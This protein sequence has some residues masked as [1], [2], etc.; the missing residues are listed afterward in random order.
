MLEHQAR[1]N[2]R[3]GSVTADTQGF[4][5]QILHRLVFRLR[6][7][8]HGPVIEKS[9]DDPHRQAGDCAGDDGAEELAVIDVAA[10]EGCDRNIGIHPDNLS[11]DS[12]GSE[13]ALLLR[14]R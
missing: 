1:P 3:S 12:F 6:D 8:G 7:E 5:F 14:H 9:G 10:R 13:K 2:V 11:I 4:P